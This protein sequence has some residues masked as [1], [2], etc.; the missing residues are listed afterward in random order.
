MSGRIEIGREGIKDFCLK[1]DLI[2]LYIDALFFFALTFIL[3]IATRMICCF[4]FIQ[5]YM[6][7]KI[8][9]TYL[10]LLESGYRND[11]V[12]RV[13]HQYITLFDTCINLRTNFAVML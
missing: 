12:R 5:N 4:F 11:V 10:E 1:T 7:N 3:C 13:V 9:Y 2:L 8:L 6:Q